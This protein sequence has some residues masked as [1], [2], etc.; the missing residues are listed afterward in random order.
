MITQN[1]HKISLENLEN[2]ENSISEIEWE[3]CIKTLHTKLIVLYN[4]YV[5]RSIHEVTGHF[6]KFYQT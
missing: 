3:P 1:F 4:N 5:L 2:S 6:T